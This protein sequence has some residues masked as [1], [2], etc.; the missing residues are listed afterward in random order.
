MK[1]T[2]SIV[3]S[4]IM[5]L[6]AIPFSSITASATS[7]TRSNAVSWANSKVGQSIDWDGVYGA[8][9]VDLMAAYYNYLGTSTPG[10]NACAYAYNSLPS[11]WKRVQNAAGVVPEPGDIAVYD[12]GWKGG[13]YG[14][15][16]IVINADSYNMTTVEQYG[17][18]DHKTHKVTYPYNRGNGYHLWGFI[19]PNFPGGSTS[20]GN[21]TTPTITLNKTNF[22]YGDTVNISWTK[23]VS[24]TD[25]YQYWVIVTNTTTGKQI[26]AGATGSAGN[27]NANSYSFK[28]NS[29]G[30]Y[31][32]T[33]YA[34]PYN[35]K[36]SRQKSA[37]RTFTTGGYT[38][39]F[40][41]NGGSGAPSSVKTDIYGMVNMP[42]TKPTYNDSHT[43]T[44]DANGGTLTSGSKTEY[45]KVFDYWYDSVGKIYSTNGAFKANT[46]LYAHYKYEALSAKDPTKD[47]AYFIG[48]YDSSER[49]DFGPTGNY[50]KNM[51]API[52]KNI[53]L[54]A[55]WSESATRLFGDVDYNGKINGTDSTTIRRY[56]D[57]YQSISNTQKFFAD[58]NADGIVNG[59]IFQENTTAYINNTTGSPNIYD[60]DC[61]MLSSYC[62]QRITYN[63]FQ[64]V[65]YCTGFTFKQTP[66]TVYEYGEEF[67]YDG[68]ILQSNYSHNANVHHYVSDDIVIG[69]YDPYKIGS[70]TVTVHFYQWSLN[71]NVTVNSPDYEVDYDANGGDVSSE[72]KTVRLNSTYGTLA[73]PERDGYTFLGWYTEKDGGSRVTSST[74]VT[75]QGNRTLYA[76]WQINT[77]SLG[78]NANGGSGTLNNIDNISY[79]SEVQIPSYALTKSGLIFLGWSEEKDSAFADYEAGDSIWIDENTTLYAVWGTKEQTAP[80]AGQHIHQYISRVVAPTCTENGYTEK[81][82][83]IC[84]DTVKTD[85]TF[86]TGHKA[87]AVKAVS[88]TFKATGKTAGSKC[89]VCGKILKAQKSVAKLKS[90]KLSKVTKAK[91]AFSAKW[92]KINGIDGYQIRYSLESNMKSSKTVNVK[93]SVTSK[94]VSKLKAKKTYY[95]QIRAY[96]TINGKKIYSSWSAKKK[97]TTKK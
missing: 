86:A 72:I 38:V 21:M 59:P 12:V 8:Q 41:A 33:V 1:K 92:V 57:N 94:K 30:A 84:G 10:G 97:V 54:Y 63:D 40:N 17:S 31:S 9:C 58:V 60:S 81:M 93:K 46:T 29:Y 20:N 91:K 83:S 47:N 16:A 25:F 89:S 43:V 52:D 44:F 4:F 7:V 27:V 75:T 32:V 66:K 76:H 56:V 23:T 2:L 37:T 13:K 19:K 28:I 48:W 18:T 77:Y 65:K 35:D 68:V 69:G 64:A 3:L 87:I 67:D 96:K 14:H 62:V 36:N 79:G 24:N 6:S 39:S 82:C 80:E 73:T 74:I 61:N 88:A 15:I 5:L 95:V 51:S 53:T 22:N 11:G 90:P 42:S 71:L 55:M 49:N 78:F 50:Y 85:F 34:V 70:Q 26:Y 45:N